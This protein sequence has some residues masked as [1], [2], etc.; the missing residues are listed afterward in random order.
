[1]SQRIYSLARAQNDC[2]IMIGAH[3]ALAVTLYYSGNFES[4]Q[5]C[6]KRGVQ[7]WRSASVQSHME[8]VHSPAVACMCFAALSDWHFGEIDSSRATMAEAISLAK[9]LNDMHV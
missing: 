3:N 6:A 1:M 9:M 4:A 7:M 5:Q 2:A 8:E